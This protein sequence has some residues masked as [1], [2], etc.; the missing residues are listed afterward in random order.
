MFS[1]CFFFE[2]FN[3][4]V[5]FFLKDK[6]EKMVKRG[7]YSN[8]L[9]VRIT[10]KRLNKSIAFG[11]HLK[12]GV[13]VHKIGDKFYIMLC[14]SLIRQSVSS[15]NRRQLHRTNPRILITGGCGQLGVPLAKRLRSVIEKDFKD[16]FNDFYRE[17]YGID[18]VVLSDIVRPSDELLK[19]GLIST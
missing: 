13:P 2:L 18:N 10:K 9:T 8:T 6:Q 12:G 3:G 16:M 11:D 19:Q 4:F 15:I 7:R 14:K 5:K 1:R 17:L